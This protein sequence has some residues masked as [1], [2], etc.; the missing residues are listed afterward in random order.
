MCKQ[1]EKTTIYIYIY[2]CTYR[3]IYGEI[4]RVYIVFYSLHL[5]FG[6]QLSMDLKLKVNAIIL[7]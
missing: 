1:I 5:D 3:K 7:T 6:T 2:T 4:D